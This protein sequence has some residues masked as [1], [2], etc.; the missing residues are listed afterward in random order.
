MKGYHRCTTFRS[1]RIAERITQLVLNLNNKPKKYIILNIINV[2]LFNYGSK[3]IYF[4]IREI[5]FQETVLQNRNW[6]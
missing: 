1:V 4:D 3:D 6:C 5:T 2:K